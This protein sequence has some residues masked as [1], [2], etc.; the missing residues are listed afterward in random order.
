MHRSMSRSVIVSLLTVII[1]ILSAP[2][3]HAHP[4]SPAQV[5]LSQEKETCTFLEGMAVESEQVGR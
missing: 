1:I 2:F 4:R 3:C 5:S